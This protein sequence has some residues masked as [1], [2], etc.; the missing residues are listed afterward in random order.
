[1]EPMR[2]QFGDENHSRAAPISAVQP[3][4]TALES[5]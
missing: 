3:L 4:S 1:M 2:R 5:F